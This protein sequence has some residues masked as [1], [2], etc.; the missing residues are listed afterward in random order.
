MT[1]FDRISSPAPVTAVGPAASGDNAGTVARTALATIG[2]RVLA[3]TAASSGT[4]SNSAA[5]SA[6]TGVGGSG[7]TPDRAE[8]G[9]RGDVYELRT[10][11]A[12][13]GRQFGASPAAEGALGRAVEDF[14]RASALQFNGRAGDVAAVDAV[15]ARLDAAV[16]GSGPGGIEEVTSRI[17]SAARMV[18]T[19]NR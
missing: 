9:R 2:E 3:W 19:M 18:E 7:F 5:W 6:A 8:L 13:I 14:A 15:A 4:T 17:E 1:S 16:A 10:L 11:T 12:E